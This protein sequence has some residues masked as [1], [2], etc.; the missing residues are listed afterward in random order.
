MLPKG[1]VHGDAAVAEVQSS[2]WNVDT[3]LLSHLILHLTGFIEPKSHPTNINCVSRF[4]VAHAQN[5]WAFSLGA[6]EWCI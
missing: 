2:V 1:Q 3:E 6:Y 5:S 4:C